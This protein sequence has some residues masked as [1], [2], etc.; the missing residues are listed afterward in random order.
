MK[1]ARTSECDKIWTT[2]LTLWLFGYN[3]AHKET[4]TSW[5]SA[6]QFFARVRSGDGVGLWCPWVRNVFLHTR[7]AKINKT[8]PFWAQRVVRVIWTGRQEEEEG[9]QFWIMVQICNK[10]HRTE[11]LSW[12][13]GS[14]EVHWASKTRPL[15]TDISLPLLQKHTLTFTEWSHTCSSHPQNSVDEAMIGYKGKITQS[16]H[17]YTTNWHH[18]QRE[19]R[20]YS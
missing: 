13:H 8:N 11:R 17:K 3:F 4:T 18:K 12:L 15:P 14:H 16:V 9:R 2:F 6:S 20:V 5:P 1:C 19:R 7:T 10:M